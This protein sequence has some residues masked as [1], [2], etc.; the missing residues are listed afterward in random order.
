M[1]TWTRFCGGEV[2]D[3]P[4]LLWYS[5]GLPL[6]LVNGVLR[7]RLAP[8]T[9]N[10][11]IA[12]VLERARSQR[13]P[14]LWQIGPSMQPAGLG[15]YLLQHGF[16][17]AGEEPAMGVT[18][19]QLPSALP[20]PEGVTITRVRDH[21]SLEH[22]A[23]IVGAGY[24]LPADMYEAVL[25]RLSGMYQLGGDAAG[26]VHH[27]LASLNGRPV[28]AASLIKA[29]GVAGISNVFTIAAER[30][31]GIG[32]AITLAPLLDARE[33]G[34]HIGVLQATDMGY[35]LYARMGFSEQFRYHIYHRWPD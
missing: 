26:P 31:R 7:A 22:W 16:T 25:P 27:Y 17:A 28:A 20:A 18:L 3:E 24:G 33:R 2:H 19:A 30:G 5:W 14:I 11:R 32:T 23:R 1:A 35:S 13:V 6:P 34:Y 21:P 10:A 12:W 29:A 8:E 15:E 4:D 9:V